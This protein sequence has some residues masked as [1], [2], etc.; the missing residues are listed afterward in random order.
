MSLVAVSIAA[1]LVLT[2]CGGGGDDPPPSIGG[3]TPSTVSASVSG[4]ATGVAVSGQPATVT[5]TFTSQEGTSSGLTITTDLAALPEGWTA[6]PAPYTCATVTDATDTCAPLVLTYT[7]TAVTPVSTLTIEYTYTDDEG[8][9]QNGS[10][11]IEYSAIASGGA[12]FAYVTQRGADD[13]AGSI[14]KCTIAAADGA[15][16][17]APETDTTTQTLPAPDSIALNDAKSFAYVL[18]GA[19]AGTTIYKCAVAAD[20]TVS[21]CAQEMTATEID[22]SIDLAVKGNFFYTLKPGQVMQCTYEPVAGTVGACIGNDETGLSVAESFTFSGSRVWIADSSGAGTIRTCEV[23]TNTGEISNC[24]AAYTFPA[25]TDPEAPA[26]APLS[27]A[28]DTSGANAYV[29]TRDDNSVNACKVDSA[30]GVLSDCV[31]TPLPAVVGDATAERIAVKEKFVYI[32]SSS[33]TAAN[34]KVVKCSIGDDGAITEGSCAA[35]PSTFTG[36]VTD[37]A[38]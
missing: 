9:T 33:G 23:D 27:I 6:S 24:A 30:T 22:G 37:I 3:G 4:T 35:D 20:G 5:L 34:N 28:L 14:L 25:P 1:A 12:M 17:C 29:V 13:G 36:E 18:N 26:P 16:T 8:A 2:G 31:P 10:T 15:L 7:P 32:T 21:T 19:T 38:L 11:A